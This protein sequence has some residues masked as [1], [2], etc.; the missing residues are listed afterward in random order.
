MATNTLNRETMEPEPNS[1]SCKSELNVGNAAGILP[2]W[3]ALEQPAIHRATTRTHCVV[4]LA[5][6]NFAEI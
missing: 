4:S 6:F 3:K 2:M 5:F 1:D